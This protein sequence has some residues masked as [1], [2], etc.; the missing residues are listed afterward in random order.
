MALI[1]RATV[2][3]QGGTREREKERVFRGTTAT[4]DGDGGRAAHVG[5]VEVDAPVAPSAGGDEA[6]PR[7]DAGRAAGR[8]GTLL[9]KRR[10]TTLAH[11]MVRLTQT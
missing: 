2:F 11:K 4:A 10:R 7:F 9:P 3:L 1:R 6:V 5:V 8:T